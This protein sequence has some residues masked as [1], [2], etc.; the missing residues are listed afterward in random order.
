MQAFHARIQSL[1]TTF[2]RKYIKYHT[3]SAKQSVLYALISLELDDTLLY[4]ATDVP[5]SE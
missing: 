4:S 1:G 5:C 3:Y 2:Y